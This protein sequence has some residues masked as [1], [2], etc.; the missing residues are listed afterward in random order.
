[1]SASPRPHRYHAATVVLHGLMALGIIAA[2]VM[3]AV[4]TDLP[5]SPTRLKLYN[6]HK[7]LGITLLGLAALRL[8]A[9]LALLPLRPPQDRAGNRRPAMPC[10]ACSTCASSPSP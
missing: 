4:M 7:W 2:F 3:G 8:L 9:R 10:T 5:F 6:W 1:M